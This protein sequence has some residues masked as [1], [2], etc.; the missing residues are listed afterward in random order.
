MKSVPGRG[1]VRILVA[2]AP[3]PTSTIA[4]VET[5]LGWELIQL[6]GLTETSPLITINRGAASTT[7][8]APNN[9]PSSSAAPVLR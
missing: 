9:A 3:P 7:R 6:Y 4:R 2:G 5:E 8:S 1:T